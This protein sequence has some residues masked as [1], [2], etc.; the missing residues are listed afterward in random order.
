MKPLVHADLLD[1]LAYEKARESER[2]RVIA[3]KRPR[4]IALGPEL[5]FIFENRDSVWFQVQ[6][7]IRTERIVDEAR[8]QG[9]LDVYN[10]LLPGPHSLSATLMIEITDPA[11]IRETLD[12]LIGIDEHIFLEVDGESVQASFDPKQFEQDRIS[13]VQYVRFELG[14]VLTAR[15]RDP[16]LPAALRSEHPHYRQRSAIEKESRESLIRDL[17]PGA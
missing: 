7:M 5:T 9:E 16:A 1:L 10:E 2:A 3:L 11:R 6:E 4:R 14:P 8:I 15:F 17:Q 13:A 12:R